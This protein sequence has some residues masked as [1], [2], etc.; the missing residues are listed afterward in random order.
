MTGPHAKPQHHLRSLDRCRSSIS[1]RSGSRFGCC[2]SRKIRG[3]ARR[4]SRRTNTELTR[5]VHTLATEIHGQVM[6]KS[7]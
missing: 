1:T 3:L 2:W 4:P 5:A 6:T 7:K